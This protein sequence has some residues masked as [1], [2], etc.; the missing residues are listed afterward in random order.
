M[1]FKLLVFADDENRQYLPKTSS[2]CECVSSVETWAKE[3]KD[4]SEIL[5]EFYTRRE[6]EVHALCLT[7]SCIYLLKI[8]NLLNVPDTMTRESDHQEARFHDDKTLLEEMRTIIK[9]ILTKDSNEYVSLCLG[10]F[11]YQLCSQIP[12]L[13]I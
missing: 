4:I 5:N 9:D 12:P 6:L 7:L 10:L 2:T 3:R 13:R 11:C 8:Q 1:L